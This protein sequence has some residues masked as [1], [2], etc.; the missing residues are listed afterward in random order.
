ML[1][2]RQISDEKPQLAIGVNQIVDARRALLAREYTCATGGLSASAIRC[3]GALARQFTV[4]PRPRHLIIQPRKK[5]LPLRINGTRIGLITLIELIYVFCVRSID[6]IRQHKRRLQSQDQNVRK[7]RRLARQGSVAKV[8]IA[9]R[10]SENLSRHGPELGWRIIRRR[11]LLWGCRP[12]PL[13]SAEST[14][15]S[16]APRLA[17][18]RRYAAVG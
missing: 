2:G 16:I 13:V 18:G 15:M 3:S 8:R 5:F 7:S 17:G 12:P 11:Q 4:P 6:K 9:W 10:A 14:V 1:G